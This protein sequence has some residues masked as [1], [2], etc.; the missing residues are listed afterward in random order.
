MLLKTKPNAYIKI[1]DLSDL[2]MFQAVSAVRRNEQHESVIAK[3]DS[4]PP[5]FS[6]P[7]DKAQNYYESISTIKKVDISENHNDDSGQYVLSPKTMD[8]F[9]NDVQVK[10][11]TKSISR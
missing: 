5:R 9:F 1:S 8:N 6:R 2:I 4:S 10:T 11:N 3:E 7:N